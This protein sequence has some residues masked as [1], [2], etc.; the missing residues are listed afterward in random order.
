MAWHYTV[1]KTHVYKVVVQLG[2][3]RK[4]IKSRQKT[5]S[6]PKINFTKFKSKILSG[7]LIVI[8]SLLSQHSQAQV[9]INQDFSTATSQTPPTGW[10]N[11]DNGGSDASQIWSFDNPG[12]RAITGGNPGF[13]GP[14][15]IID[16]DDQGSGNLQ[17]SDLE[18][19]TFNATNTTFSYRLEFDENWEECCGAV[20]LVQV[21]N[22]TSWAT[23]L[24]EPNT[25]DGDGDEDP[26]IH[27]N[28][29]ITAATGNNA[30]A[31][32]RFHYEGDYDY[33]WAL[34]NIKITAISC[35]SPAATFTAVP[36]C[37]NN[38]FSVSVN[39]TNLGSATSL[40][41][42]DGTN[43][44]G[45]AITATGTYT[46]G[47]FTSGT[48]QNLTLV[49]NIDSGCNLD[50]DPISYLCP[51]ANNECNVA[52]TL[53]PAAVCTNTFGTTL[54]ASAGSIV[55][56]CESLNQGDVWYS[57]IAAQADQLI[58]MSDVVSLE[59]NPF[60]VWGIEL[61]SGG[62]TTPV[63]IDC[64]TGSEFF[65]SSPAQLIESGLTIGQT[66]LIRVWADVAFDNNFDDASNSISFNICVS[67]TP[68][69]DC[70]NLNTPSDAAVT[71][72][73]PNFT[74]DAVNFATSYN[75]Y[76]GQ[77]NPPTTLVA[78]VTDEEYNPATPLTVGSTYYWYVQPVGAGGNAVGCD[79]NTISFTVGTP[80]TNDLAV[81]AVTLNVGQPCT[82][83]TFT[84]V[85][86][87]HNAGEPFPNCQLVS[88]GEHSVWYKFVAPASGGVK[89][90]TDIDP[91]GTLVDTKIGLFS[92]G[93]V[94]NYSTFNLIACDDDNGITGS[95][96]TS[97]IFT[98]ALTGGQTYY[99]E[100]DGYNAS[101]EGTFCLEVIEI[102]P[103][104]LSSTASCAS[105]QTPVSN[106]PAY[107]GWV[108]LVDE[109]GFLVANVRNTA[110]G[111]GNG[112]S[113]AYNVDGNGF[114]MPRTDVNGRS[115]L[116]RNYMIT[117]SSISTP[118]DVRFYFHPGEI[119]TLAGVTSNETNLTNLNVTKQE[120]TTCNANFADANGPSTIL[121]QNA[122]GAVNG[123]SWIQVS[124]SS[125]SNFYLMGGLTPLSIS[126]SKISAENIGRYNLVKWTT[127]T[128]DA[129]DYFELERGN[130]GRNFSFLSKIITNQKP[131]D[132]SF[133]DNNPL[134]NENFYRLKLVSK[135]GKFTYSK[136]VS[137]VVKGAGGFSVKA[138]PNPVKNNVQVK[139]SGSENGD[140]TLSDIAGRVIY[141]SKVTGSEINI[142]LNKLS[143]GVYFIKYT[144]N[145]LT[146]TIKISKQ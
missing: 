19:P 65:G 60:F 15:A 83:N 26:S 80:P 41:I 75:V 23:V 141:Q 113:G 3:C 108:T 138:Y 34:D 142:D 66:Y 39:V 22:G 76:L 98:T 85:S 36:D 95:G 120:G 40:S 68:A 131:S 49:H 89:I 96:Y 25:G 111:P 7:A 140:I 133:N 33:W 6:M 122:N 118:V 136:V 61:Y 64:T 73:Q 67:A 63:A 82:G 88:E 20:G 13:S 71:N 70:S 16:S 128:E 94:T 53:T 45:T 72:T 30:A 31:K 106:N 48:T 47:P 135:D 123:V 114:G 11:I 51:A 132:Y 146:K 117:N 44:Y 43:T 32:V 2:E 12:G 58:T 99:V 87:N 35:I 57:F 81:N 144:D 54:G 127:A 56:N 79:A 29:D 130:D 27:R 116:S 1:L 10:G 77:T 105:L 103:T 9:L 137:A 55:S 92:V 119:A 97:T 100:V 93:D 42:T 145:N 37:A 8:G 126:L 38:Q 86:A 115:Y 102:N 124:T 110:G 17:N 90:T 69:P 101:Q 84:N 121:M 59:G 91:L 21:W 5:N 125:F 14:F 50:A 109:D 18:T 143:E 52:Q 46:A 78:N 4:P 24:T 134:E 107:T 62:C 139:V 129:G 104:M 74:W 28:I 112:Y